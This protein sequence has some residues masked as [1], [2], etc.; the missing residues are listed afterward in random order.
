MIIGMK[1]TYVTLVISWFVDNNI[2]FL[3][4]KSKKSKIQK[5]FKK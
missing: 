5:K 1:Y 3:L 2:I 4:S